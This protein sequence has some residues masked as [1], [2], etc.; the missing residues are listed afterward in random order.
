MSEGRMRVRV[1]FADA[2]TFHPLDLEVPAS[3]LERYDRLIDGLQE[4]PAVLKGTYLDMGRL[5]AA[6]TLDDED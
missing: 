4:D 5:C 2:G 3:I 6:W 1:L